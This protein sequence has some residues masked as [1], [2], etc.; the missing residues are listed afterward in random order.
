MKRR[1]RLTSNLI[2][3]S[4]FTNSHAIKKSI[5]V[6]LGQTR[7]QILTS[8][9]SCIHNSI[10]C[11]AE[12]SELQPIHEEPL[13]TVTMGQGAKTLLP[14]APIMHFQLCSQAHISVYGF[15]LTVFGQCK[16]SN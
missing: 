9:I 8:T 16:R 5:S 7:K 3:P 14:E 11:S 4:H 1:N 15:A 6:L 12:K 10:T 2:N 13:S